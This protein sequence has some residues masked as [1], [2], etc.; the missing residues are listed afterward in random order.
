MRE[1]SP[2]MPTSHPIAQTRPWA[3]VGAV[4]FREFKEVIP[5]TVFFFVGFNLILFTKRLMLSQYLIAYAGFLVATTSALIVGKVVL[6]ADKMPMLRRFDHAP[7]AYP[8]LF[9]ALVYT[10]FVTVARLLEA[11]IHYLIQGGV[12]G[13]GGF[14]EEVLGSFSWPRFIATQ[15]WISV[16]FLMYVTAYELN[17]LFGDGELFRILFRRRA[18]A[19]KETRRAR[20]RLLT[21]LSRLTEAHSIAA[22]EDPASPEHSEL[23]AILRDLV[24]TDPTQ[25]LAPAPAGSAAL[26]TDEGQRTERADL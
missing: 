1:R 14:V 2:A 13:S 25:K 10:A 16:L 21:R 20:I 12:I 8:I 18:S 4:I 22:L 6:I 3:R 11:L 7:L 19:L 5:P 15:L 24:Q 23:V 26:C 17:E 9:K